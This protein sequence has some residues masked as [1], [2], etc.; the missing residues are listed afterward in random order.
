MKHCTKIRQ[1]IAPEGVLNRKA[2][3]SRQN[4]GCGSKDELSHQE[5]HDM[6]MGFIKMCGVDTYIIALIV[7]AN[8]GKRRHQSAK[9][10]DN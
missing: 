2:E 10:T 5:S 6:S 1:S 4:I 8:S 9:D 3:N 7:P